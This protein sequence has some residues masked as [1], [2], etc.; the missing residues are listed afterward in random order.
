[1]NSLRRARAGRP[2]NARV[3]T[4]SVRLGSAS[5]AWCVADAP[6]SSVRMSSVPIATAA[7]P[8]WIAAAASAAVPIPPHATIARSV[9]ART[10]R[11]RSPSGNAGAGGPRRERAGVPTGR[12]ALHDQHVGTKLGGEPRLVG[13]GDGEQHRGP[14]RCSADTVAGSGKPKVKLTTGTGSARSRSSLAAQWSS[15]SIGSAAVMSMP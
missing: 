11:T 5:A 10:A 9:T 6:L 8:A 3:T 13:R 15:S 2:V 14:G 4:V 1:M 7:A 12:G